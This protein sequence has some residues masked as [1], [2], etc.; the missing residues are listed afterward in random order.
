MTTANDSH[1][2]PDGVTL[3]VRFCEGSTYRRLCVLLLTH[4]NIC[5]CRE[6][7]CL[8]LLPYCELESL[9]VSLQDLTPI[10]SD[11]IFSNGRCQL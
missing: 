3:H 6:P 4:C 8:L 5:A 1:W 7:L 2:E 10:F 9:N 11:P